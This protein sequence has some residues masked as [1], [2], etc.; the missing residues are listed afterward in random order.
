MSVEFKILKYASENFLGE[1]V[2][3][4]ADSQLVYK[5]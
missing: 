1:I 3:V 2:M 5:E 4:E